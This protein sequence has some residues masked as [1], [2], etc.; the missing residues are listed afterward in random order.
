MPDWIPAFAFDSTTLAGV[1]LWSLALYLGFSPVGDWVI[2]QLIQGLNLARRTL[3]R[4]A[5]GER[6]PSSWESQAE[7]LA[8]L[9]SILPFLAAGALCNFLIDVGLGQSWAISTGILATMACGIYELGRRTSES[10]NS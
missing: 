5:E 6:T 3:T 7:F 4:Q 1:A 10:S 8:S 9:L 2:L